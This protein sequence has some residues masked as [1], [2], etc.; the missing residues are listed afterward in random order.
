MGKYNVHRYM[1]LYRELG[2]YHSVLY[3]RD[4]NRAVQEDINNFIEGQANDYTKSIGFFDTDIETFLGIPAPANTRKDKKPLN[5]MWHY[6]KGKIADEKI[7]D[8]KEKVS[9]LL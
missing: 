6:T 8:L 7:L 4:Q 9:R 1:N 3:D 5:I 2:I